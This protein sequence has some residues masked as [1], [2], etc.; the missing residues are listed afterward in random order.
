MNILGLVTQTLAQPESHHRAYLNKWMWP[1]VNTPSLTKQTRGCPEIRGCN[2]PTQL[3]P[4]CGG[5]QAQNVAL[6]WLQFEI[7]VVTLL[8][9][10]SSQDNHT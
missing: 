7:I 3:I 8:I 9:I 10:I 6:V 1:C 4:K 2:L 5:R